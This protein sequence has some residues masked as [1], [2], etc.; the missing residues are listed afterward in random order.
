MTVIRPNLQLESGWSV[1]QDGWRDA[2]NDALDNIDAA[3]SVSVKAHGAVGDGATDDTA[4]IMACETALPAGGG[5]IKFPPGRYLISSSLNFTKRVTLRGVGYKADHTLPEDP[6]IIL[7]SS[8]GLTYTAIV[9][10]YETSAIYDL[11]VEGLPG[12]LGNGIQMRCTRANLQNVM[13]FSMGSHGIVIGEPG[14]TLNANLPTLIKVISRSNGGDGFQIG[15][16]DGAGGP[17]C[18]G[19]SFICCSANAN[20]GKGFRLN[21]AG[22]NTFVG[23]HAELNGGEGIYTEANSDRNLFLGGDAEGNNGGGT[24]NQINFS[25]ASSNENMVIGMSLAGRWTENTSSR[26]VFIGGRYTHSD[27]VERGAS[28]PGPGAGEI[29]SNGPAGGSTSGAGYYIALYN[30]T[31]NENWRIGGRSGGP[32]TALATTAGQIVQDGLSSHI[33]SRQTANGTVKL[34]SGASLA[35]YAELSHVGAKL[36]TNENLVLVPSSNTR[37]FIE[38]GEL[39][40]AAGNGAANTCRLYVRDNGGGK[41]GVYVRFGSGAEVQLGNSS[42][43]ALQEP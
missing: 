10:H 43:A 18:N 22:F 5:E 39:S 16:S 6:A 42:G 7:K 37:G 15:A 33:A 19:G 30:T 36:E 17:N 23:I 3:S 34:W 25:S 28:L 26:S 32:D 41:T 38:L 14:S 21:E 1:G 40:S 20:T 13:V 35:G 8:T 11:T 27:A 31:P 29:L 9:C 4:A 12:N 2:M 24:N